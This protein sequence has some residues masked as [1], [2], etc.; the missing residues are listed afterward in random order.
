ME[1]IV[2]IAFGRYIDIQNGEQD[3]LTE[4]AGK[5]FTTAQEDQVFSLQVT[6]F[7]LCK[8]III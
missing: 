6:E 1:T 4:A 8:C 7:V 2:A 5:I 3:E